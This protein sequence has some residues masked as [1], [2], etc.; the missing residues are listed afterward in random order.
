MKYDGT[1]NIAKSGEVL[2]WSGFNPFQP[3]LDLIVNSSQSA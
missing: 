3:H 1:C 2:N